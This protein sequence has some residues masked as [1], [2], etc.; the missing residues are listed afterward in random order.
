MV[1]EYISIVFLTFSYFDS[2]FIRPDLTWKVPK[3]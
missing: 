1:T 3:V 2:A